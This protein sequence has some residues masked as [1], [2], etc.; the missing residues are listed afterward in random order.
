MPVELEKCATFAESGK[1]Y[2]ELQSEWAENNAGLIDTVASNIVESMYDFNRAAEELGFGFT[3]QEINSL[4]NSDNWDVGGSDDYGEFGESGEITTTINN[5][6]IYIKQA[7][8]ARERDN[9]EPS[10][11]S[12]Y[13]DLLSILEPS[14]FYGPNYENIREQFKL[15]YE[16][17]ECEINRAYE[18]YVDRLTTGGGM[19]GPSNA[20]S[21][22]TA[23]DLA[24]ERKEEALRNLQSGETELSDLGLD[25]FKD[26]NLEF[27]EQCFLLA[28]IF[29]LAKI[30]QIFDVSGSLQKRL[31]YVSNPHND[32]DDPYNN[33]TVMVQGQP[34]GFINK[35]TQSPTKDAFFEMNNQQLSSLQP[36]IRL[37]KIINNSD[38]QADC[39]QEKQVEIK[40]NS[41]TRSD[42]QDFLKN[43]NN[44]L[45][46]VGLKNFSFAYE[47]NNPFAVKKSITAKISIH[48]NSFKELLDER[49]DPST[50]EHIGMWTWF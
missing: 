20:G 42:V 43:K 36:M 3:E 47:G 1:T 2:D 4:S 15:L 45:P 12:K 38:K 6:I 7:K 50:G 24:E 41:N 9:A 29:D 14:N 32:V 30:K 31:P 28:N 5:K 27:K 46:G 8:E 48:A 22:Q 40:F 11:I 23:L 35:L 19:V 33:A 37:Y 21:I 26:K 34:F 16:Y 10:E 13:D 49:V 39:D 18:A 44:R 25:I 17:E